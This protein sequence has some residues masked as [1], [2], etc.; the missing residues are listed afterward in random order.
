V[1]VIC[2]LFVVN[3]YLLLFCFPLGDFSGIFPLNGVQ[4]ITGTGLGMCLFLPFLLAL[5]KTVIGM[6]RFS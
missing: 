4:N 2:G 1:P 3:L 5:S 6:I